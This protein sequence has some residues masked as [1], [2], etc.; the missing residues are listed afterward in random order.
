MPLRCMQKD[1][2][3]CM[4]CYRAL[5]NPICESCY[6]NQIAVWLNDYSDVP[7][8]FKN[9]IV[10][11]IIDSINYNGFSQTTCLLCNEE[12]LSICTYCFF[13]KVERIL[14]D[15]NLSEH[16]T[17]KFQELFNYKL[18]KGEYMPALDTASLN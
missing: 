2:E 10:S 12:N 15:S 4:N 5:T 3:I 11:K 8:A 6:S 13:F 14:K 16:M 1:T 7:K 17:K 18:Y 9:H